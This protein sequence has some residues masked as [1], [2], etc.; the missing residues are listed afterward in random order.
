MRAM[1]AEGSPWNKKKKNTHTHT[2]SALLH[3]SKVYMS[4][5]WHHEMEA[6]TR[7]QLH[8]AHTWKKSI[9]TWN[10][11]GGN[12]SGENRRAVKSQSHNNS[13]K[14]WSWGK[15]AHGWAPVENQLTTLHIDSTSEWSGS[16]SLGFATDLKHR[17]D[18]FSGFPPSPSTILRPCFP[19]PHP[20]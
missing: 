19:P 13:W 11:M 16:A 15:R 1:G 17:T 14:N 9:N 8:R 3:K 12:P 20:C 18:L 2:C 5:C 4:T 7:Q 6:H 10:L